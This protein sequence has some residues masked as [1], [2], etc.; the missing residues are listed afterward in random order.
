VKQIEQIIELLIDPSFPQ[1]VLLDG[2]WGSG[3][4]HFINHHL[5]SSV[6]KQFNQKVY[7]F[8]LYGISNID[9]FRDKIISLSLTD[10]EDTSVLAKY[11]S[12][13]ID[14][15]ANN[16]GERG[17][18]AVLSGAAG[19]YKY[20][21]YG[22]L[23][24]CVLILDDLERVANE[25]LIKSILGECLS[26]A[27]SKNIKV[28]VV[29]NEDKLSCKSDIEKVFADKYK[30]SFT[31]EEVVAI[32]KAEYDCL[33]DTL[34]N[35]LLLNITS[36]DSRNIRVLKRA[37]TKFTRIKDAIT[38]IEDVILD[39]AFSMVMT[40]IIRICYAKFEIG[41]SKEK[42][43]DAM[44]SVAIRQMTENSE[45]VENSE[46]EKI[47]SIFGGGFYGVNEKLISYCCDG[48]YEFE[49]LK[50]E[51]SLPIKKTL[52]DEMQSPWR[53]NQL[54]DEDFK[55]GVAMFEDFITT[56]ID[57]D[58][59]EWFNICDTY[60]Y[61]L[62]KKIISSSIYSKANILD[63]CK[64][65]DIGRFR[66]PIVQDVFFHEDRNNFH[67]QEVSKAYC[68]K[69]AELDV[70]VKEHE[71][72]DFSQKFLQSWSNVQ[73]EVHKNLMHKPIFHN[74][75]I[76]LIEEALLSWS[77][78]DVFQFV[79]F[80]KSRYQFKS[81][82]DYFE[83]EIEALKAIS[84]VLVALSTQLEVGLKVFYF[85]ELNDCLINACSRMETNI[86]KSNK[87]R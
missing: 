20:K 62:D 68:L 45:E 44:N 78:E 42:I 39:Q 48:L 10:K 73:N 12:K 33:D 56:A 30:F 86:E 24:D 63:A 25:M 29:A 79:R 1:V 11:L 3:K 22:E 37:L 74:I 87:L 21:L 28:V 23:D 34:A 19:A 76:K 72:S 17:I 4:T 53:Q 16:L 27:E 49:N 81:I 6:E 13:A 2:A 7:F 51:L 85:N 61:M 77:N 46:Y 14:G 66:I 43:I 5:I 57:V 80:S 70:L 67:N 50:E 15:A 8:S 82:Q 32:L 36:I 54:T 47:D 55:R 35:E 60:I 83:P 84:S 59:D 41:F 38:K 64:I 40:D 65:V 69:I 31:H 71:N 18:G 9:D 26:L 52:L 58:A 75:S